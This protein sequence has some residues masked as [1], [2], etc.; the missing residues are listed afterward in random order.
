MPN[1][2]G[3]YRVHS[4]WRQPPTTRATPFL[5]REQQWEAKKDNS[6]F[7]RHENIQ[8]LLHAP[9]PQFYPTTIARS[10]IREWMLVGSIRAT[11]PLTTGAT[12]P[13]AQGIEVSEAVLMPFV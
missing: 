8:V 9:S 4:A 11:A 5:L 12:T 10:S 6:A 3:I 2:V 7:P 13:S 1:P